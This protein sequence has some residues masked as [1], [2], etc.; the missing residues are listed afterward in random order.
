MKNTATTINISEHNGQPVA[1]GSAVAVNGRGLLIVGSPGSGK[2]EMAIALMAYGAMLVGDDGVTLREQGDCVMISPPPNIE[3][4][5]EI[6]GVGI[7]A[8]NAVTARLVA[9]LDM[10]R[11]ETDR[12]PP[13]RDTDVLGHATRCLHKVESP[14]FPAAIWQYLLS[15]RIA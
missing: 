14:H 10:D 2:S 5:I 11:V 9:V 4:Q 6:R 1:R 8:A 12:L 3:G 7:M 15:E 13:F